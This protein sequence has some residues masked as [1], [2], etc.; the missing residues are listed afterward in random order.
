MNLCKGVK[1]NAKFKAIK[2]CKILKSINFW[3]NT[4]KLNDNNF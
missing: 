1:K 2:I 4:Q 3:K